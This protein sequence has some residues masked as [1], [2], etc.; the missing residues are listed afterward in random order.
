MTLE[1]ARALPTAQPSP[2]S[3]ATF[4]TVVEIDK[5]GAV[6][7]EA[8]AIAT[9]R[10]RA[11]IAGRLLH[12]GQDLLARQVLLLLEG[13]DPALPVIVDTV[14]DRLL[15]LDAGAPKSKQEEIEV[16]AKRIAFKAEEEIVLGCGK[17][18][19]IL[20][21]DGEVVIRGTD[22]LSRSSGPNRIK[23]SRVQVN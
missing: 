8:A 13:G 21:A 9:V 3:T 1:K 6:W 22:L 19:V 7:I 11:K 18:A 5:Q 15:P 12:S 14:H 10:V 17:S 2:L 20:S 4:G 23:G 16:E